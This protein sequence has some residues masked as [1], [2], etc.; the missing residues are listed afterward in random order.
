MTGRG[1]GEGYHHLYDAAQPEQQAGHCE[2][3]SGHHIN[4][5]G[6]FEKEVES[7]TFVENGAEVFEFDGVADANDKFT[8]EIL[9]KEN[10]LLVADDLE[11]AKFGPG[12]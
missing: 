1:T 8:H 12:K 3:T 10:N 5:V 6:A 2:V 7:R 4:V 11:A 9:E